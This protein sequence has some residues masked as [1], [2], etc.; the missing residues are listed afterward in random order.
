MH[1]CP[2]S[3]D[4][5]LLSLEED[6]LSLNEDC[7]SLEEDADQLPLSLPSVFFCTVAVQWGEICPVQLHRQH[8]LLLLGF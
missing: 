2:L 5:G 4:A 1:E 7:L 6:C 3:L 8:F